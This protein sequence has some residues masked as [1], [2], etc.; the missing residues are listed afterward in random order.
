MCACL[1]YPVC[2]GRPCFVLSQTTTWHAHWHTSDLTTRSELSIHNM[3]TPVL[4]IVCEALTKEGDRKQKNEGTSRLTLCWQW[5][6]VQLGMQ[7]P[8]S[9]EAH[10]FL[11]KNA[12]EVDINRSLV[13]YHHFA[14]FYFLNMNKNGEYH[15]SDGLCTDRGD[16]DIM[17]GVELVIWV[18]CFL[19]LR[20]CGST[21][22]LIL[23]YRKP[24]LS[25]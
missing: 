3:N 18:N 21:V 12:V 1:A 9:G 7:A 8:S 17:Q 11:S 15:T 14:L 16:S 4:F 25:W 6:I 20:T 2:S 5:S 10:R 13:L 22:Y 23:I 24:L 19:S